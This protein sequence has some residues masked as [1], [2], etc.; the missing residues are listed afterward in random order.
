MGKP[1]VYHLIIGIG[2]FILA[3]GLSFIGV[4]KLLGF[5]GGIIPGILVL[6]PAALYYF[7][8]FLLFSRYRKLKNEENWR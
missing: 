4:M 6:V 3:L 5:Y 2:A 7:L 8:G 1:Y